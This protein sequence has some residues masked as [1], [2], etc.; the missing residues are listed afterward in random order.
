MGLC[1]IPEI[2]YCK[3][4][5]AHKLKLQTER[6]PPFFAGDESLVCAAASANEPVDARNWSD[7][8]SRACGALLLLEAAI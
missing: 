6:S 2:Q 3:C 4:R 1:R 7:L 5:G 8:S